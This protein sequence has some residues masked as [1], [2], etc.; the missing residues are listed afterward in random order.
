MYL[1]REKAGCGRLDKLVEIGLQKD[2][3][4]IVSKDDLED[5]RECIKDKC[6]KHP[7]YASNE[8]NNNKIHKIMGFLIDEDPNVTLAAMEAS[9][10]SKAN[11]FSS[12]E[13]FVIVDLKKYTPSYI[14]NKV[15]VIA[16]GMALP[17]V[18]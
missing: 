2:S 10:K 15:K 17:A 5:V 13:T 4:F 16:V 11:K 18:D 14:P 6:G 1:V 3:T 8:F 9:T 7:L 12:S